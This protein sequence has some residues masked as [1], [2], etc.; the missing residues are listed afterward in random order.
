MNELLQDFPPIT[1]SEMNGISLMNRIDR[2]YLTDSRVLEDILRDAIRDGYRVFEQAGERLHA[3]DSIYFDTPDL[4]MFTDHRRGKA[5][6]QKVRTRKYVET[7]QC[8]LELKRKNNHGRTCKNRIPIPADQ[9]SDYRKNGRASAWLADNL[10]GEAG[11]LTPSLET[12]FL[13]ITL[14]NEALTERLTIDTGVRFRNFRTASEKDLGQA[15]IIELKQDGRV[16]SRMQEILLNH[17]VKPV[18]VSKYCVGLVMTD[19]G[20]LPGKFKQKVRTIEK[21][22]KNLYEKCYNPLIPQSL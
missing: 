5:D 6:R 12:V 4:K 2:K 19:P 20:L 8:Y 7:N 22:N 18:R 16:R 3:Y 14:V 10:G 21:I 17:R 15:V 11:I 9:F 13:R 1:L